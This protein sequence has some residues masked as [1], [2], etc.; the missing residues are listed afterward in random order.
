MV[1][2]NDRVSRAVVF[3]DEPRSHGG[4]E[5]RGKARKTTRTQRHEE[6]RLGSRQSHGAAMRFF[7]TSASLRLCVSALGERNEPQR[8]G[9]SDEGTKRRSDGGEKQQG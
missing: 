1:V 9:R 8:E 3:G 4:T 2:R 5:Q 7:A 6:E